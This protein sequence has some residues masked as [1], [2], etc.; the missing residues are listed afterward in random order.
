MGKASEL[1]FSR[2]ECCRRIFDTVPR[3]LDLSR[4]LGVTP[5][6]IS[7]TKKRGQCSIELVIA[8]SKITG[9]PIEWFLFGDRGQAGG[10]T[11]GAAAAAEEAASGGPADLKSAL[12]PVED[13]LAAMER[14]LRRIE[15]RL[16]QLEGPA[17]GH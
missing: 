10:P 7:N 2:A 16:D 6:A 12:G 4:M 15:Q 11:P 13:R 14:S 17:S 8:A 3:Q 5:S 1:G 9:R